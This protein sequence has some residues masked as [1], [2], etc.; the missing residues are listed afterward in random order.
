M[1][2]LVKFPRTPHLLDLGA[3]TRDDLL[4]GA[5]AVAAMLSQE[6]CCGRAQAYRA[7]AS[8]RTAQ[9]LTT[10]LLSSCRRGEGGRRQRGHIVLRRRPAPA[11][12]WPLDHAFERGSVQQAH[13][14]AGA[15]AGGAGGAAR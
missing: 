4:V 15:K 3:T 2:D 13:S 14:L 7:S 1:D 5:D 10:H 6:L 9:L 12:A 11:E 8:C